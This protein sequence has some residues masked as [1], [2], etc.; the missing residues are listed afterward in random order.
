MTQ[1]EERQ[2]AFAPEAIEEAG[3]TSVAMVDDEPNVGR[4]SMEIYAEAR[5]VTAEYC[6]RADYGARDGR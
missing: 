3:G 5:E 6:G 1:E 2:A 4:L